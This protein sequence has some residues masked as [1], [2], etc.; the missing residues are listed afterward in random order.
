MRPLTPARGST[1]TSMCRWI[2][3]VVEHWSDVRLSHP[4]SNLIIMHLDHS[5]LITIR[6]IKKK[7]VG[8]KRDDYGIGHTKQPRLYLYTGVGAI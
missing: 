3:S 7:T 5:K 4:S 6:C 1:H 8:K 2:V